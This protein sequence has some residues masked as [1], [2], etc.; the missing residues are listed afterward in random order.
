MLHKNLYDFC[1]NCSNKIVISCLF[2]IVSVTLYIH[3]FSLLFINVFKVYDY[4]FRAYVINYTRKIKIK[5]NFDDMK[6]KNYFF[7]NAK[8]NFIDKIL[9]KYL[10]V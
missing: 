6:T 4:E 2:F 5:I 3:L 1:I 9:I 10:D 8:V 7:V